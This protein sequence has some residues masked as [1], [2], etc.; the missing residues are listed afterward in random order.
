[1]SKL[2]LYV[3]VR[4]FRTTGIGL[5]IHAWAIPEEGLQVARP[6]FGVRWMRSVKC[7]IV[8]KLYFDALLC[9]LCVAGARFIVRTW[10]VEKD[11]VETPSFEPRIAGV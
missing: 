4:Q 7:W 11:W 3:W 9:K 10:I 2:D 6:Y 8:R 5:P 1:M